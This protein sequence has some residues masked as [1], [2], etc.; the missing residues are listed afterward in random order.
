M[1]PKISDLFNDVL[2]TDFLLP[3]QTF[4]F[5]VALA[6]IAAYAVLRHEV[7]RME[8]QG[9]FPTRK[10]KVEV[11]GPL[12]LSEVIISLVVW[13]L[14]GYKL[15]LMFED[16]QGFANNPQAA[17]LSTQ[18]S[19]LWALI[20]A[21]V[22]GGYRFYEYQKRKATKAIKQEVTLGIKDELGTVL[23]I[24]FVAGIIGAKIFHNLEY[25]DAFVQDPI[26]SLFSF[27]G[28]T[29]YGGFICAGIGIA[30]YLHKKGYEVLPFA[31]AVAPGLILAYGIGRIGCHLSGDGDWGIVNT[32]PKPGWLSWAPDWIWA[33]DYPGNVI[34]EGVKIPGCE[35]DFCFRLDPPVFPTPFYEVIM[36]LVIF[37]ILWSLRK[38][39]KYWGQ[40]FAAYLFLN[41]LERFWIEKIRVNS[42]YHLFGAEITQA[43]IISSM[44]MLLGL[45]LFYFATFRWKKQAPANAEKASP[46]NKKK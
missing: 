25:W 24:A 30:W 9:V 40:M 32:A 7:G 41:G 27:D 36:A 42:T 22:G 31:D 46:T 23:T 17:L 33:F 3:I 18:G 43:E 6:F 14:I 34:R 38:T 11:G 4:G 10:S 8:R 16:Y 39:L 44:L 20:F 2:G 29:F 15:G 26:G 12:K 21:A 45:I 13:G 1:Y 28:L 19:P 35:G 37:A 5:F